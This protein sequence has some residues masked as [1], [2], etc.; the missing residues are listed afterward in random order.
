MKWGKRWGSYLS[1]GFKELLTYWGGKDDDDIGAAVDIRLI[2]GRIIPCDG[3]KRVH[4]CAMY[5]SITRHRLRSQY[6]QKTNILHHCEIYV[7]EKMP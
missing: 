3:C 6:T 1:R 5:H 4:Y 2:R 7:P